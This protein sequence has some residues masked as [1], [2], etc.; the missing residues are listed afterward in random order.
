MQFP[1]SRWEYMPLPSLTVKCEVQIYMY[2]DPRVRWMLTLWQTL[3]FCGSAL[4]ACSDVLGL[5]LCH[6]QRHYYILLQEVLIL[7]LMEE[8]LLR[9]RY[10]FNAR[11]YL[12]SGH[13]RV[14]RLSPWSLRW[15]FSIQ[16]PADC[17]P[18]KC[19]YQSTSQEKKIHH[20]WSLFAESGCR[21]IGANTAI[22]EIAAVLASLN[23]TLPGG[24]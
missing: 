16:S 18:F 5:F 9:K 19:S 10:L 21:A 6:H 15:R 22:D 24:V 17:L 20:V 7:F 14:C 11:G 1:N 4:W 2:H 8:Y 13:T 3:W 12:D 23:L